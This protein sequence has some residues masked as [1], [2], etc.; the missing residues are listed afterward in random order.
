V[1][2]LYGPLGDTGRIHERVSIMERRRSRYR[3]FRFAFK[4]IPMTCEDGSRATYEVRNAAATPLTSPPH[5]SYG[6]AGAA[7][8]VSTEDGPQPQYSW[9]LEVSVRGRQSASGTLRVRG[10]D[11][12]VAGSAPQI[13]RS[14]L[15]DWSTAP[16]A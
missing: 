5:F 4:K 2:H 3:V 14:G 8:T 12:E 1:A 10:D 6:A 11:L 7:V 15:L 13:C 9:E 16:A